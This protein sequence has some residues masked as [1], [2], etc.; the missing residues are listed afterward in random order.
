[1]S[2]RPDRGIPASWWWLFLVEL[3]LVAGTLVYWIVAPG[4]YL[5]STLGVA[6]SVQTTY[7]LHLYA[8]TVGS[9][10]LYFYARVLLS[11]P[12]E[13]RTF[14]YLQEG[15]L[16]GDVAIVG[17]GLANLGVEGLDPGKVWAQIT[18]AAVWGAIRVVFLARVPV[19]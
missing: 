2:E 11:R 6:P 5:E 7:L 19:R 13:L 8:G 3:P 12:I 16:I 4:D 1:M 14:R 17:L 15:F 10:A 9:L 18:L